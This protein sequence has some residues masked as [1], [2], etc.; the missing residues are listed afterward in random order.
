MSDFKLNKPR[1]EWL[2]ALTATGSVR[3]VTDEALQVANAHGWNGI[4]LWFRSSSC[5]FKKGRGF[6]DISAY[7]NGETAPLPA[8]PS[9]IGLKGGAN[10]PTPAPAVE[11]VPASPVMQMAG[12][13]ARIV[14]EKMEGYVKWGHHKTVATILAS[15]EFYPGYVTGLSG[16]GKT[17][18]IMQAAADANREIYRVNI[19][20]QTDEDDLI[21]GFRLLNG[22]T[23]WVDGPAVVAA[24]KGAI[25]L[26]DEIDLGG[27]ALMCLQ[28]L[29]EG[30]GIFVKKTGE[31]VVPAAGFNIFATANTKGKGDE[32]GSFAHTGIMNEA[33]LD[34]FPV[35]LEQPY[36]TEATEKK[37]LKGKCQ[38]FGVDVKAEENFIADLVAWANNIR[39]SYEVGA[40]TEIITTRRLESIMKAFAIFGNHAKA[41]ERGISRFDEQTK[42]DMLKLYEKISGERATATIEEV[43]DLT[44]SARVNLNVPYAAK[45]EA[46]A[47]GAKWDDVERTWYTTGENYA[48]HKDFFDGYAPTAS[49][50]N[51]NACPW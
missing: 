6:W 11:S 48:Q 14:P 43:N 36:A 3:F 45:E 23:V 33:M 12:A 20:A 9:V 44:Q 27:P 25:L 50:E 10:A 47:Y 46:K 21:G 7:V 13:E 38:K 32:T 41:I 40:S 29:L 15:G 30:N 42:A 49:Q 37:I 1:R 39:K 31:Y 18:M 24:K 4:P 28:P 2:D 35:T 5:P 17:T 26:L 19:T 16:N 8:P 34:R 51:T 22:D